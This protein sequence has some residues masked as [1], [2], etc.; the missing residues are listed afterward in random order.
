MAI[1]TFGDLKKHL[2]TLDLEPLI[3]RLAT[4]LDE[5]ARAMPAE[6]VAVKL[7]WDLVGGES[8]DEIVGDLLAYKAPGFDPD[9]SEIWD[10]SSESASQFLFLGMGA[11]WSQAVETVTDDEVSD[12][13]EAI[14]R[15][16]GEVVNLAIEQSR[17]FTRRRH[18]PSGFRFFWSRRGEPPEEFGA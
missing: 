3:K 16:I 7:E 8:N 9:S 2:G 11:I 5:Q 6:I 4:W 1:R 10:W 13:Q 15:T 12:A 17:E 18:E 14:T